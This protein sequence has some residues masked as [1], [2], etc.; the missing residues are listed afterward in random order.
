[1]WFNIVVDV[2]HPILVCDLKKE[3][4]FIVPYKSWAGAI[5]ATR[6]N[7]SPTLTA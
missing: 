6:G 3:N 5:S 7:V 4:D 2:E 1:M